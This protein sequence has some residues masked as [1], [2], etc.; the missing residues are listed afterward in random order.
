[1]K[2]AVSNDDGKR[3]GYKTA[4]Q[5]VIIGDLIR[6]LSIYFLYLFAAGKKISNFKYFLGLYGV[7]SIVIGYFEYTH[8]HTLRS[9]SEWIFAVIA[10][11]LYLRS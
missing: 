10:I 5:I 9:Y 6:I 4:S 7:S 3:K 8:G 1:M 2:V 11:L